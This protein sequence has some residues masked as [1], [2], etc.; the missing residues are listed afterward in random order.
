MI[1][2]ITLGMILTLALPLF[3]ETLDPAGFWKYDGFHYDGTRYQNPNPDLDL[4]FTFG[5][6]GIS[7]LRWLRSNDGEYCE[8]LAT[9][10]MN[11]SALIQKVF[12]L[13]PEN[14]PSCAKDPDMKMGLETETMIS[15]RGS[16]LWMEM[17]LNGKPFF[18]ILAAIVEAGNIPEHSARSTR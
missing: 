6:D 12:W 2:R 15:I 3:G 4:R 9:Y 18:Y 8:R 11:G 13:N 16:E 17:D 1:G 10:W 5:E 14:S 7:R